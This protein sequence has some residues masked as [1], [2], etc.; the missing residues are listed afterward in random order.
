MI[1]LTLNHISYFGQTSKMA[2]NKRVN[3]VSSPFL[4]QLENKQTKLNYFLLFSEA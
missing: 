4:L 2:A 3:C 1:N